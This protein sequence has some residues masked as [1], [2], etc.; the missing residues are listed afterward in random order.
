VFAARVL[1]LGPPLSPVSLRYAVAV[2]AEQLEVVER[3]RSRRRL[4]LAEWQPYLI[5][6]T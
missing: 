1:R 5:A 3:G 2:V 6:T 4:S